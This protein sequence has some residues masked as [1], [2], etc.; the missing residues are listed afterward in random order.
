MKVIS[1]VVLVEYN[2]YTFSLNN[3]VQTLPEGAPTD[4][5]LAEILGACGFDDELLY[6]VLY[7]EGISNL[8]GSEEVRSCQLVLNPS[9]NF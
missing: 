5:K 9:N 3:S 1:K 2:K 6:L 7:V 8:I 4:E